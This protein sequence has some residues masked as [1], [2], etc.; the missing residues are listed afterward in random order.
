MTIVAPPST[1]G[2]ANVNINL[3]LTGSS[4]FFEGSAIVGQGWS[5]VATI[6]ESGATTWSS[7]ELAAPLY[8]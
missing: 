1:T 6:G 7:G 8:D 2:P 5:V 4:P 3:Y